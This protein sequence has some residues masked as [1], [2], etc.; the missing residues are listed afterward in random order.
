MV[1]NYRCH[2]ICCSDDGIRLWFTVLGVSDTRLLR[3]LCCGGMVEITIDAIGLLSC[4]VSRVGV[5][6]VKVLV[7]L[8]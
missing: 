1:K 8:R 5:Y 3:N 2:G 7:S 4:G 6:V